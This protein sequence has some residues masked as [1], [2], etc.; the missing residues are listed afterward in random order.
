MND[1]IAA[2]NG[3]LKKCAISHVSLDTSKKRMLGVL[4]EHILP[5]EK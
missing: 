4:I 1:R 3:L 2:W 5:K